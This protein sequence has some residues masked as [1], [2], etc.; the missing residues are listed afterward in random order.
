M[1]VAGFW[2]SGRGEARECWE[3]NG[4]GRVWVGKVEGKQ[5][6]KMVEHSGDVM[7]VNHTLMFASH[8]SDQWK[9]R[10]N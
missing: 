9:L 1:P 2:Y 10:S 6:K 3:Q 7:I 4:R 8:M 5:E